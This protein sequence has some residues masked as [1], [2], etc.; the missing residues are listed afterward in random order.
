MFKTN[1]QGR[2]WFQVGFIAGDNGATA[3]NTLD[4]TYAPALAYGAPDP[5][6]P[7]GHSDD[8]FYVGTAGGQVYVTLDGGA[9][10]TNIT[11]SG[12][13]GLNGSPVVAIAPDTLRAIVAGRGKMWRAGRKELAPVVAALLA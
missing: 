7:L 13:T 1:T 8:F 4:G 2:T 12:A 9:H 5:A 6:D 10:F 11:G 3:T